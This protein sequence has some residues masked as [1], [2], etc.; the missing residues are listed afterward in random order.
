MI[1]QVDALQSWDY[2]PLLINR[3]RVVRLYERS[4]LKCC[5]KKR[6]LLAILN[7]FRIE[8]HFCKSSL[9]IQESRRA[10][11]SSRSLVSKYKGLVVPPLHFHSFRT[12]TFRLS[13]S[14]S[15][16]LT[17]TFKLQSSDYDLDTT[18]QFKVITLL[19][20]AAAAFPTVLGQTCNEDGQTVGNS[21]NTVGNIACAAGNTETVSTILIRTKPLIRA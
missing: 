16:L 6:C 5:S 1:L 15:D 21:C 12:T 13:P 14:Q 4:P 8:R 7:R 19:A 2:D 3:I 11:G 20:L 10:L 18:M 9:I 17:T